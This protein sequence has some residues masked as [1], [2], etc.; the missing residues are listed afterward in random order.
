LA[1]T[2]LSR[3]LPALIVSPA[4]ALGK[5]RRNPYTNWFFEMFVVYI[6]KSLKDLSLYIGY[7]SNLKKRLLAHSNGKVFSTKSRRPFKLVYCEAYISK[8]DAM[9]REK[10]LKL[11]GRARAQLMR[12]IQK[13]LEK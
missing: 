9:H 2:K 1:L 8:E 6:L 13:S 12:R 7:S 4:R 3:L 10:N 5:W 11:Y